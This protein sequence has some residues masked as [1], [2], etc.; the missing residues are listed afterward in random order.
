MAQ[1]NVIMV[2]VVVVL[3]LQFRLVLF[4]GC[5]RRRKQPD[6]LRRRRTIINDNNNNNNT[7][8]NTRQCLVVMGITGHLAGGT[9]PPPHVRISTTNAMT[10]K[11][12]RTILYRPS[13]FV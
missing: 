3:L 5:R 8:H 9:E 7:I 12:T 13:R 10:R 4:G 11:E 1:Y 6:I 2:P